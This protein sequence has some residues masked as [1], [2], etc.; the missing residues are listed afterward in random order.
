MKKL[1]I[2]T[3]LTYYSCGKSSSTTNV[4]SCTDV[5]GNNYKTVQIGNQIWMAENL[6]AT[7]FQNGDTLIN[8]NNPYNTL[9]G[10]YYQPSIRNDSRLIAPK[11]W[12]IASKTDYQVLLSGIE[13]TTLQKLYKLLINKEWCE[14]NL[15]SITNSTGLSL[16]PKGT[17]NSDC[18]NLY[19]LESGGQVF[20]INSSLWTTRL[21]IRDIPQNLNYLAIRC[22][23]N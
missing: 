19:I 12:R 3:V 16:Y 1:I 21:D 23:K 17:P 5:N 9:Q 4:A 6:R 18:Q 22:I 14:I 2:L 8:Y 7:K 10:I 15:G 11:G 20:Y 13:G